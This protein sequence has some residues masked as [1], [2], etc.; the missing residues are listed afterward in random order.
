MGM[1]SVTSFA[2]DEQAKWDAYALTMP[3]PSGRC[4]RKYLLALI[5]GTRA[6]LRHGAQRRLPPLAAG[7]LT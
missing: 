1:L 7:T 3:V 4:G 5:L 2:Y 6:G